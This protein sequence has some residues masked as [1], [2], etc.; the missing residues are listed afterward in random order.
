MAAVGAPVVDNCLSGYNSSVFAYG[1]TGSGKTYTMTG[2][3]A[4]GAEHVSG[5]RARESMQ[6]R[7]GSS[8][9]AKP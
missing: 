9:G 6:P 3:V 2:R 4:S 1:Q 7:S 8:A 5:L